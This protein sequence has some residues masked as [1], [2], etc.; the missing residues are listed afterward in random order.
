MVSR[1]SAK[2]ERRERGGLENEVLA[3]LGASRQPLTP[4]AVLDQLSGG[5]A[6]T[7]VMTTLVRLYDKGVIARERLGRAYA[8]SVVDASTVAARQMRRVLDEG[9]LREVVLARFLEELDPSDV[10]VLQRLLHDSP[11]A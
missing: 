3:T 4:S 7:T 6:Y 2:R 10:P 5:L 9:E 8:Y 1:R 11:G